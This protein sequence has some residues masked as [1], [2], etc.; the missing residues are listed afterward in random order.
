MAGSVYAVGY[1]GKI[2]FRID[3]YTASLNR[4]GVLD[5]STNILG[6]K[7]F[8]SCA[9]VSGISGRENAAC[10]RRYSIRAGKDVRS[11]PREGDTGLR[12]APPD[13]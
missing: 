8:P 2:G 4:P 6:R 1:Q 5:F 10:S 11:R 7:G 12:D 3:N 13:V 9:T